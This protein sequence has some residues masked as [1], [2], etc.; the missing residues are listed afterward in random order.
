MKE[1]YIARQPIYDKNMDLV[2]YELLYRGNKEDLAEIQDEAQATCDTIINSFMDVGID[3]LVGSA[4]AYIN[5]PKEFIVG[6]VFAPFFTEQSV[7]ELS[8]YLT[9]TQ[10]VIDGLKK[11]KDQGYEIALDNFKYDESCIP[12]LNLA[13]YVKIDVLGF[14][15]DKLKQHLVGHGLFWKIIFHLPK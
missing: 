5:F 8:Q 10:E 2:G 11:L 7:L 1:L 13:D 3:N 14:D 9:P 12:L 4:Q 15:E 6:D